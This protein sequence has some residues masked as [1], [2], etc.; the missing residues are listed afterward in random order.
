MISLHLLLSMSLSIRIIGTAPLL[1]L[2][3]DVC[4]VTFVSEYSRL[5][6]IFKKQIVEKCKSSK[7]LLRRLTGGNV[8][9]LK[10]D[11]TVSSIIFFLQGK[12]FLSPILCGSKIA[13][14]VKQ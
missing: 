11:N 9:N 6:E 12:F 14:Y 2:Q 13:L 7:Y 4:Y 3:K 8:Q 5:F 10:V 1:I